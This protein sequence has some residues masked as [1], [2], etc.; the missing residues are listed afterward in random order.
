MDQTEALVGAS[1]GCSEDAQGSLAFVLSVPHGPPGWV[2]EELGGIVVVPSVPP[3]SVALLF[4][5]FVQGLGDGL[6]P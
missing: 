1:V 5:R 4:H 6:H 2:A 3:Q